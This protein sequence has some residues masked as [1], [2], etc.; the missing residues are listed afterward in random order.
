MMCNGVFFNTS[1][2]LMKE[3]NPMEH[4][5]H[6]LEKTI[7]S[8]LKEEKVSLA[9]ARCLFNGILRQIE[10]NNPIINL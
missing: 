7:L 8:V 4:D 5:I 9:E 2:P 1:Q 3:L 6:Y 10:E